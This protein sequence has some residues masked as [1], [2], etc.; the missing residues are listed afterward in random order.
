MKTIWDPAARAELLERLDKLT[1]RH[2]VRWG[3]MTATQAL[4]HLADPMR[5]ALGE[6]EVQSKPGPFRHPLVR[7]AIIYWMPWP[8]GAPTAPEF[9][10]KEEGDWQQARQALRDTIVRFAARG[11]TGSFRPHPAFG[12]ISAK[13]WGALQWR[14]LDHHL[15]QFGIR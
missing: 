4:L 12:A 8:K 7:H 11:Q 1:P 3:S 2:K 6:I 10:H 5:G 14:H 15:R 13:D 9:I